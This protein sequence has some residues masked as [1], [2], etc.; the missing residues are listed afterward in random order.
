MSN[1][2]EIQLL[3]EAIENDANSLNEFEV[4]KS[5][6]GSLSCPQHAEY[7][8][9]RSKGEQKREINGIGGSSCKIVCKCVS[10]RGSKYKFILGGLSH[11]AGRVM[12][13]GKANMWVSYI[14]DNV[15]VTCGDDG[16]TTFKMKAVKPHL[17]EDQVNNIETAEIELKN[18][19]KKNRIKC[20]IDT[21]TLN[22]SKV[23]VQDFE[24]RIN[25][26][27]GYTPE[28]RLFAAPAKKWYY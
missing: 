22:I 21:F 4:G 5:Y 18:Y 28:R 17:D 19:C 6:I 10:K 11:H 3:I 24:N 1:Y 2:I 26:D 8:R 15:T 7:K 25:I 13:L 12:A 16:K 20:N 27:H 9:F 14:K 23:E